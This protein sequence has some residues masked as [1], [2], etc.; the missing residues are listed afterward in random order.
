MLPKS[1]FEQS[2]PRAPVVRYVGQFPLVFTASTIG[3][4]SISSG[5]SDPHPDKQILLV[6]RA[7]TQFLSVSV[8]PTLAGVTMSVIGVV[9]PGGPTQGMYSLSYTGGGPIAV[10]VTANASMT[11]TGAI[12]VWE[13]IGAR[14]LHEGAYNDNALAATA[15]PV[16]MRAGRRSVVVMAAMGFT[17]TLAITLSGGITQNV[18]ADVGGYRATSGQ[19]AVLE[20]D[21]DLPLTATMGVSGTLYVQA[22]EIK[23]QSTQL[24][25]SLRRSSGV[26]AVAGVATF[27]NPVSINFT[28][29][30]EFDLYTFIAAE[31]DF[32]ITGVTRGGVAMTQVGTPVVFTTATPDLLLYCFKQRVTT[33]TATGD[34]LIT[35]SGSH[36]TDVFVC[37][38]RVYGGNGVASFG[39]QGATSTA[40]T[41]TSAVKK[42]GAMLACMS[43]SVATETVAW[44]GG[45]VD[46]FTLG[47]GLRVSYA[48]YQ[49]TPKAASANITATGSASNT[50]AIAA[51]VLEP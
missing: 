44:T 33:A 31:V 18:D 8:Y 32:T 45:A 28:G 13:V 30:G 7:E 43:R 51:L 12:D 48:L 4:A 37:N 16:P 3:N 41:I 17:D 46:V 11:E 38:L 5:L 15:V 40:Q 25:V 14:P 22:L 19:T 35:F 6:A 21:T 27:S 24:S 2:D 39:G 29:L 23:P 49:P 50:N 34:I 20:V 9:T 47:A 10:V 36:T 26:A 1:R 42:G